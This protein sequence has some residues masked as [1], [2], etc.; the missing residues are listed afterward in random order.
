HLVRTVYRCGQR[1]RGRSGNVAARRRAAAV[2]RGARAPR[3]WAMNSTLHAAKAPA[4]TNTSKARRRG[5]APGGIALGQQHTGDARRL[6][7]AVLEV[8]AGARTPTEAATALGV[9]VPRYYQIESRALQGL[10]TACEPCPRGPGR[11]IDKEL[12]AVRRD[13]QRLQ[14]DL[15]RQQSLLRAAQRTV[16]LTPPHP[17]GPKERIR[18]SHHVS[19]PRGREAQAAGKHAGIHGGSLMRGRRPAGPNYVNSLQGSE[20]ARERLRI[21]LQTVA[22]QLSVQE[23][24]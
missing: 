20:L 6:A 15:T 11:S 8:L 19:L 7:A 24:C 21:I 2:A 9:S 13:N 1:R 4:S 16:G 18:N 17:V 14:R 3:G 12:A 23:A 5:S 22:G 10:L